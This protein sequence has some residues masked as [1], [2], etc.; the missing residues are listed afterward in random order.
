MQWWIYEQSSQQ[1]KS[2]AH[3]K[4]C[5]LAIKI[6]FVCQVCRFHWSSTLIM[7]SCSELLFK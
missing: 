5:L 4:K 6:N 1:Q 2:M 3:T 7:Q